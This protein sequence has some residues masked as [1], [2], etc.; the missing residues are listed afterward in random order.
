[1]A[2]LSPDY[3]EQEVA[4]IGDSEGSSTVILAP[5]LLAVNYEATLQFR[6]PIF[7][8]EGRHDWTAPQELA[9]NW[10]E[11][12]KAPSKQLVWFETSAHMPMLEEPGHFLLRLVSDV[13]PLADEEGTS[14]P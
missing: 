3:N 8:F 14:H 1:M 7:L 5:E 11:R 2:I 4:S 9:A 13:R 12:I 6:C 10:F